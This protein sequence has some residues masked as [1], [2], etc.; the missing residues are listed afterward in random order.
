LR[1]TTSKDFFV[2]MNNSV[3]PISGSDGSLFGVVEK[4]FMITFK[5]DRSAC[6]LP[7]CYAHL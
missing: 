5:Q 3:Y 6:L 7:K 1:A 4:F 2:E